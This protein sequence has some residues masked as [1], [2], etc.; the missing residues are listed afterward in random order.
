MMNHATCRLG[1]HRRAHS[2][3][4]DFGGRNGIPENEDGNLIGIELLVPQKVTLEA[5]NDILQEYGLEPLEETD[6][7]PI[8]AA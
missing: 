5:I 3:A 6:L 7:A 4:S 8:L 1:S 2:G